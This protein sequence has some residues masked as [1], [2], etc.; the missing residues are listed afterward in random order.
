M[1]TLF[2]K[3]VCKNLQLL[4]RKLLQGVLGQVKDVKSITLLFYGKKLAIY[5]VKANWDVLIHYFYVSPGAYPHTIQVHSS[6]SY[7]HL[8][9]MHQMNFLGLSKEPLSWDNQ[10]YRFKLNQGILAYA[11]FHHFNFYRVFRKEDQPPKTRKGKHKPILIIKS[12]GK[13]ALTNTLWNR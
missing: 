4:R 9:L 1:Y 5:L 12:R 7:M 3:L 13:I 2:K 6:H 10:K 8:P 11:G